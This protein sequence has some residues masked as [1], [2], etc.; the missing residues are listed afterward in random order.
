MKQIPFKQTESVMFNLDSLRTKLWNEWYETNNE[1]LQ[2]Q[3]DE[4]EYLIG[5]IQRGRMKQSEWD[6]IQELVVERQM[7]RYVTCL[8]KGLDENI[9]AGAFND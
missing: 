9:A 1:E 6:R 7:Q 3:I 4:I 2:T 8:H 5:R